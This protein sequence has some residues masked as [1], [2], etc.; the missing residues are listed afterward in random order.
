HWEVRQGRADPRNSN[1]S[2]F[3]E[4]RRLSESV[5]REIE[6]ND[7]V[8]L[9]GEED[10][11]ASLSAAEIEHAR[12]TT[13]DLACLSGE[14]RRLHAPDPTVGGRRIFPCPLAPGALL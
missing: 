5:E 12:S 1:P 9:L 14:G 13:D 3:S 2:G 11:I 10:A 4:T 6:A 8:S 7:V